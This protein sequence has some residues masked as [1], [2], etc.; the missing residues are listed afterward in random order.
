MAETV[1]PERVT[2]HR[3]IKLVTTKVAEGGLG[4]DYLGD[5][6]KRDDNRCIEVALLRA[7][8]QQRGYSDA[9]IAQALQK[10]LAASDVTGVTLY[11]ANLRTYQ[12]LR[13]GVPVQVAAGVAHET[14][15]LIDWARPEA[16]DFALAEEVTLKGGHERRPDIVL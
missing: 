6:S 12:L 9:H 15:H 1:R 16:N 5:W 10:L 11:Q 2:Q 14:V 4:Y 7:N 8:L 13:Y 3:V